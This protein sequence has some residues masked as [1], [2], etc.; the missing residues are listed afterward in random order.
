MPQILNTD[1]AAPNQVQSFQIE[2]ITYLIHK[3]WNSRSGWYI[4]ISDALDTPILQGLLAVAN[5]SLTSR[6]SKEKL[7]A[8]DLWIIDNEPV[9]GDLALT[10]DNF[11]DGKRFSLE[12]IT[13]LEMDTLGITPIR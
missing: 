2:G 4:S 7:F 11:G 10:R 5:T 8:G 6:Y 13:V 9:G 1:N 12:Y 3:Y